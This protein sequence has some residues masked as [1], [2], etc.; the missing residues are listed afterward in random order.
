ME[1]VIDI[2]MLICPYYLILQ[3]DVGE[4]PSCKASEEAS[5][6][7][8]CQTCQPHSCLPQ[9]E[10]VTVS[11]HTVQLSHIILHPYSELSTAFNQAKL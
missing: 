8:S 7:P 4:E 11:N 6:Y 2:K 10:G 5:V 9:W 1:V 3:D